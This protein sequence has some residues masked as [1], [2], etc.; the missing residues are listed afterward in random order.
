V[1]GYDWVETVIVGERG[2]ITLPKQ[3]R[4]KMGIKPKSP[5]LLELTEQ[6]IVV[7][8]ALTITVRAFSDEFIRELAKEDLLKAGE[9]KK[10]L[11]RWEKI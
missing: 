1:R 9:K 8:P 5:V 6:G 7:K 11:A 3:Y 10:A 4:D 2:Q